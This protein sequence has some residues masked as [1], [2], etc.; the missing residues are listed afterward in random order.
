[1]GELRATAP[2]E[3]GVCSSRKLARFP[4]AQRARLRGQG[5]SQGPHLG[6][7]PS[8]TNMSL[9]ISCVPGSVLGPVNK[10]GSLPDGEPTSRGA[11]VSALRRLRMGLA[12]QV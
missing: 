3:A 1:M 4:P 2:S 11:H 5:R 12:S 9:S 7:T 10:T 8:F 6:S